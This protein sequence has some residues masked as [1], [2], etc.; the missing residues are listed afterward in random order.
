[1]EDGLQVVI[2]RASAAI[3]DGQKYSPT[4][5]TDDEHACKT[6]NNDRRAFL[7]AVVRVDWTTQVQLR[8]SS[9]SSPLI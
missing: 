4:A 2:A 7:S 5:T 8:S 3:S 1:M 6:V 9:N